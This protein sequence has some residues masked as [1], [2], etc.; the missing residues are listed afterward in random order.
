MTKLTLEKEGIYHTRRCYVILIVFLQKLV[1]K[2]ERGTYLFYNLYQSSNIYPKRGCMVY[3]VFFFF[4]HTCDVEII[5]NFAPKIA[6]LV[7]IT[8]GKT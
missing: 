2:A 6:K 8:L 3:N 4:A 1:F 7:K 5:A